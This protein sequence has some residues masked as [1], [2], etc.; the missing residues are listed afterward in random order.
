MI[1]ALGLSHIGIAVPDLE[2]AAARLQTCF[3]AEAS[4]PK[5]VPEQGIR[6]AYVA[7]GTATVELL[8]PTRPDSPV[9][10]FLQRNPGGG[11]HHIAFHVDDADSAAD[12]ARALGLRIVGPGEPRPGHHGRPIFFVDPKDILGA[13]VEIEEAPEGATPPASA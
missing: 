12:A 10:K 3:G 2:A 4:A 5:D 8:A 7:I 13:L 1:S 6:I 11:I 9:A